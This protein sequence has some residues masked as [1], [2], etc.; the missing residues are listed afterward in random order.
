MIGAVANHL[1]QSTAFAIVAALL[2]VALR[3]NKAH[4]RYWLWFSASV[5][6]LVPFALLISLGSRLDWIPAARE[7]T[8]PMVSFAMAPIDPSFLENVP[9]DVPSGPAAPGSTDWRLSLL[10]VWICGMAAIAII[11]RRTWRSIRAAV[12]A[13]SPI[14]ILGAEMPSK[15]QVR[16]SPG[17]LEPA[18]VGIWRPTLLWPADIEQHL[19][20]PQRQAVLAHELCHARRYDNLT[21]AIHMIV[22]A[23]FWFHPLVWWIGARLL[24]E[25]ERAC[26]EDVL[27]SCDPYAYADGIL[28]VCKRY[29]RPSLACASGV[30]GSNL[31]KRLEAILTKCVGR[32][33]TVTKRVILAAVGTAALALPVG[34]GAI[35]VSP[36]TVRTAAQSVNTSAPQ[37]EVA[38]IK[39]N[40][41]S[42]VAGPSLTSARQ[43]IPTPA[44]AQTSALGRPATIVNG[45]TVTRAE[46]DNLMQAVGE[47]GATNT[48]G[49][50]D[51]TTVVNSVDV[52]LA[53]QD[54]RRLGYALSDEQFRSVVQNLRDRNHL[55]TE[56]QFATALAAAGLSAAD[57][58]RN[59]ERQM[60]F[61]R[62]RLNTGAW[63]A[64]LG[65]LRS[66]ATIAWRDDAL[67]DAYELGLAPRQPAANIR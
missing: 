42:D 10:G 31:H 67:K 13:S 66:R 5:K 1:W 25:R 38:S 48:A 50:I 4:I 63:N 28:S 8:V 15:I 39:P 64:H 61:N 12:H 34:V 14:K 2:A 21:A 55:N 40:T 20:S 49:S 36:S 46:L 30:T 19:T 60:I 26:D 6:F 16:S 9:A 47:I 37:F 29:V 32:P 56:Q 18:I 51:P 33:L 24:D 17:L 35:Q 54:G 45:E 41:I 23:V 62:L 58:R 7:I 59:L 11:R 65:E 44:T 52:V 53:A 22:E 57:L 43:A 3:Q 27:R